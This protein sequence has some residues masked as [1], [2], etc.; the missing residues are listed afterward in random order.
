M[1]IHGRIPA[2]TRRLINAINVYIQLDNVE[3]DP[4]WGKMSG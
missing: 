4:S 2:A 3:W 1:A